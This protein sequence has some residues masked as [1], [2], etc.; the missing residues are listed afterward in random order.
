[1][2]LIIILFDVWCLKINAIY[3][4]INQSIDFAAKFPYTK[5]VFQ[6]RNHTANVKNKYD[7]EEKIF[8]QTHKKKICPDL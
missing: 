8:D 4:Y 3:E 1:M 7:V 5:M 2:Y 6:K